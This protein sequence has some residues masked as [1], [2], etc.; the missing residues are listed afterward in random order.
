MVDSNKMNVD[1]FREKFAADAIVYRQGDVEYH[2]EIGDGKVIEA[3]KRLERDDDLR[4]VPSAWVVAL[5][6]VPVL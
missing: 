5:A 1:D 3:L 6:P 4:D 2:I